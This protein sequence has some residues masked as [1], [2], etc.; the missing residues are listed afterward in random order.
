MKCNNFFKW[1]VKKVISDLIPS[2]LVVWM[3][4]LNT[5]ANKKI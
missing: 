2:R 4:Q 1:A 5:A 3:L